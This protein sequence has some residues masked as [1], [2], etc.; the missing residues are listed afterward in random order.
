M[1]PERSAVTGFRPTMGIM[2]LA[3]CLAVLPISLF[4]HEFANHWSIGI[5][6]P[7]I[8]GIA[9]ILGF[10]GRKSL[11]GKLAMVVALLFLLFFCLRVGYSRHLG[12]HP[13][14]PWIARLSGGGTVELVGVGENTRWWRPDG[15]PLAKPPYK[16]NKGGGVRDSKE[17]TIRHF[18]ARV[19]NL[20]SRPAGMDCDVS[21]KIGL[22][23][24]SSVTQHGRDV[25]NC[26]DFFAFDATVPVTQRTA[27]V[28]CGI[29]SGPWKDVAE[30]V[31]SEEG[32]ITSMGWRVIDGESHKGDLS[33]PVETKAG[34]TVVAFD[35]VPGEIRVIAVQT[36]GRETVGQLKM[37]VSRSS[38]YA[39]EKKSQHMNTATFAGLTLKQIKRIKLQYRPYEWVEF[40]NVALQPRPAELPLIPPPLPPPGATGGL[41]ANSSGTGGPAARGTPAPSDETLPMSPVL[42]PPPPNATTMPGGTGGPGAP[43]AYDGDA[44][45]LAAFGWRLGQQGRLDE[46]ITA[47]QKAIALDPKS[48]PAW[49]GLGWAL[50]T[51]GRLPE[52]EKTF[53]KVVGLNPNHPG[54]WNGL[55]QVYLAQGK[56]DRAERWLLKAAP[57][58]PAAWWGLT[59]LYL[60]QG[61]F[62]EAE[63]WARKIVDADPDNGQARLLLKAAKQKHLSNELRLLMAGATGGSSASASG[64]GGQAARGAPANKD[65]REP[66]RRK[67]EAAE[68]LVKAVV[69]RFKAGVIGY[70]EYCKAVLARDLAEADLKGDPVAAAAPRSIIGRHTC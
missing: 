54:A 64:M 41:P 7:M 48:Q 18:F 27:T 68:R 29:S 23:V 52:A 70:D 62:A 26:G 60:L 30:K 25:P 69:A 39:A 45:G 14:G 57:D 21:G 38:G 33:K 35:S 9:L 63:K 61:K 11:A 4:V 22:G 46:A 65:G 28:S 2:G 16:S 17:W 58:V 10:L 55:G 53:Q 34:L 40:R 6:L 8:G 67:L 1:T 42:L 32:E 31:F 37:D 20:P 59:K 5:L 49:N 56:Y 19:S 3:L 15:S 50:F 51:S 24:Y 44:V 36:N 43:G 66:A 47:F 12:E 13:D